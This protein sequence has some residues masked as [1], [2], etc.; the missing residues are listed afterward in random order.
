MQEQV[1]EHRSYLTSVYEPKKNEITAT[2]MYFIKEFIRSSGDLNK[3]EDLLLTKRENQVIA[4]MA[5][6][7]NNTEIAENLE[8]SET[9]VS[10]YI[11]N[12]YS[13]YGF[14]GKLSR[15]RA[16]LEYLKRI[17]KLNES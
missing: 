5:E 11:Q 10:S 1:Y 6:G 8:I 15:T 14:S 16:V 2:A 17:G 3:V 7:L 9:T 12:I 13:K 4:L